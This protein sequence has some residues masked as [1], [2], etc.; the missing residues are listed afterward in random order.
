M[1]IL[2]KR[3]KKLLEKEGW[4]IITEEKPLHIRERATGAIATGIAAAIVM[5]FLESQ[6]KKVAK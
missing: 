1:S 2:T 3:D 4:D 5:M 6:K